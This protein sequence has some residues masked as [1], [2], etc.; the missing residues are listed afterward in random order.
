[1]PPHQF[2]MANPDRFVFR[3]LDVFDAMP[4]LEEAIRALSDAGK[5][6]IL[7]VSPVPIQTSFTQ[8]DCVT[9][10]EFSKSVLRICAER[11]STQSPLVDYFPSYEIVRNAG[12][13]A[14]CEDNVH[15]RDDVVKWITE[16]MIR[17]Y[18]STSKDAQTDWK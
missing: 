15:V 12:L 17:T 11:L 3:R 9:A 7:T 8:S 2:A 16:Y 10:N 4:L 6:V 5:K 14:Y 1:M 18:M 13:Q